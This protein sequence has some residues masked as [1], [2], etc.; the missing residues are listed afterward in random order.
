MRWCSSDVRVFAIGLKWPLGI[1]AVN[2]GE[3]VLITLDEGIT[4]LRPDGSLWHKDWS[5]RG[6]TGFLTEG[7]GRIFAVS[8]GDGGVVSFDPS[9]DGPNCTGSRVWNSTGSN[10]K[11][12]G[13]I[14]YIPHPAELAVLLL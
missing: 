1:A 11:T 14:A 5:S 3:R 2:G 7:E 6:D 13:A 4:S 12:V 8:G 10:I 9:C